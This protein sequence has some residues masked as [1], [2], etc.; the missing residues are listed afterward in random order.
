MKRKPHPSATHDFSDG[1]Q[2][3]RHCGASKEDAHAIGA[4]AC[5]YRPETQ[6]DRDA[7]QLGA[8]LRRLRREADR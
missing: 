8:V 4:P 7:A 1:A 6:H 3:C 5:T 2:R